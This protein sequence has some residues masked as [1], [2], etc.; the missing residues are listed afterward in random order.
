MT[1]EWKNA[2]DFAEM[3]EAIGITTKQIMVAGVTGEPMIVIYTSPGTGEDADI[4]TA[5]LKRDRDGIL[6]LDA[7]PVKGE[8]V[9]EFHRRMHDA[10]GQRLREEF[11]E[12]S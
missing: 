2:P 9:E 10:V 4:Y 12:P 5:F 1:V 6:R 7:V 11:G 8:S 3:A